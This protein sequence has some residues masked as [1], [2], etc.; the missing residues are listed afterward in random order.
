M[1]RI[2]A[3]Y[4]VPQIVFAAMLFVFF[5]FIGKKAKQAQNRSAQGL[6]LRCGYDLRAS[7]DRCP[8]CGEKPLRRLDDKKLRQ[9]FKR[10]SETCADAADEDLNFVIH[11][12]TERE[13]AMR[14][15]VQLEAR[16]VAARREDINF[17]GQPFLSLHRVFV[18]ECEEKMAEEIIRQFEPDSEPDNPQAEAGT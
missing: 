5:L 14:L 3:F 1:S 18:R 16:Q 7:R 6:C 15:V 13:E 9:P 4:F 2:T 10:E 12:T 17:K 8:E 11:E